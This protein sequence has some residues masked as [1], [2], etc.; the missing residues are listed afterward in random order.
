[1]KNKLYT[2][3]LLDKTGKKVSEARYR[4]TPYDEYRDCVFP[5]QRIRK[6][7]V[8]QRLDGTFFG[9]ED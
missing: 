9:K 7:K 5:E 1:M 6:F 8:F 4:D 3:D 2:I